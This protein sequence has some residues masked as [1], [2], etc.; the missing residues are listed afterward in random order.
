M[1]PQGP[2]PSINPQRATSVMIDWQKAH[3]RVAGM[4][5]VLRI[6]RTLRI[7]TTWFGVEPTPTSY[8]TSHC[9][10]QDRRHWGTLPNRPAVW[11]KTSD[12]QCV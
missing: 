4:I 9:H 6:L 8:F 1:R 7:V 3:E 2:N 11:S 12:L 5:M 10:L